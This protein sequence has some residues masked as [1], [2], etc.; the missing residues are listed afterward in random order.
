MRVNIFF[1]CFCDPRS[2]LFSDSLQE[3]SFSRSYSENPKRHSQDWPG[4]PDSGYTVKKSLHAFAHR[5]PY[6]NDLYVLLSWYPLWYSA[7]II[8]GYFQWILIA[9]VN[10]LF[11]QSRVPEQP[12]LRNPAGSFLR[13]TP[14]SHP[15]LK[16]M[17]LSD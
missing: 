2:M 8:P 17:F 5:L 7:E 12:C 10:R 6:R 16:T 3:S 4:Y 15:V 14:A 13:M 11:I 1:K 9:F